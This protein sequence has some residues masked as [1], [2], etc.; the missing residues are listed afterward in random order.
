MDVID[1]LSKVEDT[2]LKNK[3]EESIK[4]LADGIEQYGE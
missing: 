1:I 4:I 3:I 2:L